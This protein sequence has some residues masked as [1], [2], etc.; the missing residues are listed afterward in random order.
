M[1]PRLGLPHNMAAPGESELGKWVFWGEGRSFIPSLYLALQVTQLHF[2]STLSI[3]STSQAPSNS[4]ERT[5][6]VFWVLCPKIVRYKVMDFERQ[7]NSCSY[8]CFS[9]K[10]FG[11]R[12]KE[13]KCSPRDAVVG[14][15][16]LILAPST[17]PLASRVWLGGA[18][19]R[20]FSVSIWKRS[21]PVPL[22]IRRGNPGDDRISATGV[23]PAKQDYVSC[24]PLGNSQA[25][26]K[27]FNH[28]VGRS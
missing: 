1:E 20:L 26:N 12:E 2:H 22:A 15:V 16:G 5:H 28:G 8:S 25:V 17:V 19:T 27:M 24:I 7:Y 4:R 11:K 10:C 21:L 3:T 18:Q 6:T 14:R 23:I 13:D 9:S